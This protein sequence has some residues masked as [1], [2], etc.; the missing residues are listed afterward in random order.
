MTVPHER[1]ANAVKMGADG[2]MGRFVPLG[3]F[4]EGSRGEERGMK[5]AT[6][7]ETTYS[8]ICCGIEGVE[9]SRN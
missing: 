7:R 9:H 2:G 3:P 4:L 8:T 1:A 5:E 6:T